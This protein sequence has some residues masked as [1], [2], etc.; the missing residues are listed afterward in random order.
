MVET[1]LQDWGQMHLETWHHN[2]SSCGSILHCLWGHCLSLSE[3]RSD[4]HSRKQYVRVDEIKT[5]DFFKIQTLGLP[6]W[7]LPMQE[8]RVQSLAWEIPHATEQLSLCTT[9]SALELRSCN[10]WTHVPP[11]LKP[12]CLSTCPLPQEKPP[13][14]GACVL[15]LESSPHLLQLEKSLCSTKGSAQPNNKLLI[16]L[17]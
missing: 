2:S 16:K 11:L 6:W 1:T 4:T 15:Q 13:R 17:F 10:Y 5:S 7:C 14:W 12:A 9:T 8:T 3:Q